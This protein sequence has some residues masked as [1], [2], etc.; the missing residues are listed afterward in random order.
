VYPATSV[1]GIVCLRF[2]HAAGLYNRVETQPGLDA[3]LG[4]SAGLASVAIEP[5][6][7]W[8]GAVVPPVQIAPTPLF[9]LGT[10]GLRRLEVHARA[11]LMADIRKL[12]AGSGFR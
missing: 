12:L 1:S 5:L 8:G 3:F 2:W 9:L 4:N 7:P 6:V 11:A 10:G